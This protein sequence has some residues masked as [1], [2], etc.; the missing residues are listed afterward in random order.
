MNLRMTS[1]TF[2]SINRRF[3][4]LPITAAEKSGNDYHVN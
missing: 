3:S 2:I 4:F 1:K